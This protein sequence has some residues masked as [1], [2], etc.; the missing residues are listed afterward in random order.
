M[1]IKMR[2]GLIADLDRSKLVA[3]EIVMSTDTGFVGIAK[4]PNDVLELAKK[5]DIPDPV[6]A[7]PS[8]T[9]TDDLTKIQIGNTVY[10]IEGG[11]GEVVE[12][13][14]AQYQALTPQQKM[15][16]TVRYVSDYPS[17]GGSLPDYSTNEQRTG[18]K[19]IDGKPVYQK[20][21]VFDDISGRITYSSGVLNLD[22][23]TVVEF[24]AWVKLGSQGGSQWITS[25]FIENNAYRCDCHYQSQDD[26]IYVNSNWGATNAIVTFKYTKT[27]DTSA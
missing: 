19:W 14:Y 24:F 13:T 16:G 27:T 12:M 8:G 5:D 22:I 20:T 18:Q 15:D 26:K 23:E 4:A 1:A 17:G 3:G 10:G 7:N 9:A 2:R 25:P 11:S 6:I 21:M